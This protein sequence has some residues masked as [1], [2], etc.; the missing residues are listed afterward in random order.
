LLALGFRVERV[1]TSYN[2]AG[3]SWRSL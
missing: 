2:L 1:L 3:L